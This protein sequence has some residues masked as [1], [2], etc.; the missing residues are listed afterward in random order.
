MRPRGRLPVCPAVGTR[1]GL[2]PALTVTMIRLIRGWH[3]AKLH[4]RYESNPRSHERCSRQND[5]GYLL[6]RHQMLTQ[7]LSGLVRVLGFAD[8]W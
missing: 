5:G 4:V 2:N 7:G 6:N 1:C 8:S 3:L